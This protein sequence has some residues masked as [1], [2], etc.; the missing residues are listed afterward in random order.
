MQSLSKS[1]SDK[2]LSDMNSKERRTE[3]FRLAIEAKM[4]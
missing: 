2:K 3:Y 1:A 4:V